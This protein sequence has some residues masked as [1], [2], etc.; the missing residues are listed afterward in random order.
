MAHCGR[1]SVCNA[2]SSIHTDTY[3]PTQ[4]HNARSMYTSCFLHLARHQDEG[5]EASPI[6]GNA[7]DV[8]PAQCCSAKLAY[9]LL[10]GWCTQLNG[11]WYN[12]SFDKKQLAHGPMTNVRCAK[13][14]QPL[15]QEN[16]PLRSP[17]LALTMCWPYSAWTQ[18]GNQKLCCMPWVDVIATHP[19]NP[20]ES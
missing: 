7:E 2:G 8:T 9:G 13:N 10:R 4:E 20:N 19:N 3:K 12:V 5:C 18:H 11:P 1:W 14:L 17:R 16:T 6:H 15:L